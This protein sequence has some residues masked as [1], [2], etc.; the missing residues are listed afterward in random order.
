MNPA[1]YRCPV[2]SCRNVVLVMNSGVTEFRVVH[3]E[4]YESLVGC[5][6]NSVG[7]PPALKASEIE[8]KMLRV[9]RCVVKASMIS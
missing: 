9:P 5:E 7:H 8:Y 2:G 3:T 4:D 6:M 1:L